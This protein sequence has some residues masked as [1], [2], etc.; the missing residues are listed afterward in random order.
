VYHRENPPED[1]APAAVRYERL[2]FDELWLVEDL[3][4]AGGI[5]SAAIALQ[6]TRSINVGIGI[7][8]AVI[9]NPVF[10]AMEVS[11]LA[12]AFPGR[13]MPGIGHG[14]QDWM[15]SVGARV[16]SPMR[17]LRESIEIMNGLLAGEAV[18]MSGRYHHVHE[19]ALKFPPKDQPMVL[20]GV[21][22]PKSLSLAGEL[23]DGALLG[24][25]VTPG[26]VRWAAEQ[27]APAASA[28]A[29]AK[30]Q[31]GV[32]AWMSVDK[33]GEAACDRLRPAL[34]HTLT[35]P[36]LAIHLENTPFMVDLHR[37]VRN[38]LSQS[39]REAA[40]RGEWIRQLA[41]AGTPQECAT[42]VVRLAEA[43]A[44]RVILMPVPGDTDRQIDA[45]ARDVMPLL[46][47]NGQR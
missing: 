32:Y 6:A 14:I 37:A 9:R 44:G 10:A 3:G 46:G 8:A 40:L 22:G 39:E 28:A 30:P 13:L 41:I 7:L 15:A 43:G 25:P 20:A 27:M 33:D 42:V 18:T 16:N 17:A 2:G 21:R 24:E 38:D 4:F 45:F 19:V 11:T 34:A 5:A 1:L 36:A 26:H 31:L 29:R 47:R 12:R 35:D 23:C